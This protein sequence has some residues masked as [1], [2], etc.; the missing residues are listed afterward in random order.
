MKPVSDKTKAEDRELAPARRDYVLTRPCVL[1]GGMATDC[2]EIAS[3]NHNR[4][5]AKKYPRFWLACCRRCHELIQHEPKAR[6][7]ARKLLSE[8]RLFMVE[9]LCERKPF[10]DPADVLQAIKEILC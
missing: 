8:P 6:Q 5:Y 3:G 7:Y 2:H 9:A 10:V 1:C 4:H